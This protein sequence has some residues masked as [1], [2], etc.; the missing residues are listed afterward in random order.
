MS[1]IYEI[2]GQYF[3]VEIAEIT[4]VSHPDK[5]TFAAWCSEGFTDLKQMPGQALSR[6]PGGPPSRHWPQR[7]RQALEWIKAHHEPRAKPVAKKPRFGPSHLHG[8]GFQSHRL[9]GLR[10]RGLRRRQVICRGCR[11]K[12]RCHQSGHHQ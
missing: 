6:Y 4:S 1:H 10:I 7:T 9:G 5:P 2:D 3:R 11:K 8:V 12:Q